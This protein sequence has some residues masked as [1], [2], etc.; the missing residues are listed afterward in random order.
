LQ[1]LFPFYFQI[2]KTWFQRRRYSASALAR[3]LFSVR[4]FVSGKGATS[5]PPLPS[6]PYVKVALHTA[7]ADHYHPCFPRPVVEGSL[8]RL[9]VRLQAHGWVASNLS[10]RPLQP[11]RQLSGSPPGPR[12]PPFGVRHEALS[13]GLG[14][15]RDFRRVAFASWAVLFPLR[16]WAVLPKIVPWTAVRSVA[17]G[18]VPTACPPSRR[19]RRVFFYP[20]RPSTGQLDEK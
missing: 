13:T 3:T 4:G 20:F 1:E 2:S 8:C 15:P 7:Q 10:F 18:D 6:E 19:N 14:I 9:G 17:R 11:I 5:P 16:V 12:Q